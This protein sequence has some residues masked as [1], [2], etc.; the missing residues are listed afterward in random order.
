MGVWFLGTSV[1]NFIGG[2]VGG[3]YESMALPTLFGAVGAFAIVAGLI[4]AVFVKPMSRAHRLRP[5]GDVTASC[6]SQPTSWAASPS[7][8]RR[9]RRG[10][11]APG[12]EVRQ[13]DLSRERLTAA[14]ARGAASWSRSTC[15]CTRPRGWPCPSSSAC[16]RRTRPAH[17][18]A[19]G[20][21]APL[22]PRPAAAR[23]ASTRCSAPRPKPTWWR[24]RAQA[25]RRTAPGA[26]G[27]ASCR[28]CSSSR[29][30]GRACR[31]S[32]RYA[33]LQ[34]PD[35]RLGAWSAT[36][37][38]RAAASTGAGTARSCRSTTAS[39]ASCRSRWCSPTSRAQVRAGRR[40]HHLRR[41]RLPQRPDARAADRRGA[42]RRVAAASPTT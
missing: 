2:R 37:R 42:A 34:L 39:S 26:A 40:A 29:P 16:A 10:C 41:P 9:R 4:L 17:L 28:G 12:L 31:R 24:W 21:Y 14:V 33:A 3:L 25:G 30:T 5:G 7:G 8:W 20:L 19:Y 1:G 38:R 18:C 11:A 35:G 23:S 27:A 6:C 13:Q 32:S 36:P 22:E 15:R